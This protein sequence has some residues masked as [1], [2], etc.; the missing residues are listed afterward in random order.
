MIISSLNTRK[1]TYL[2][3]LS[4]KSNKKWISLFTARR[5]SIANEASTELDTKIPDYVDLSACWDKASENIEHI[6]CGLLKGMKIVPNF[7]SEAEEN[8]LFAEIEPYMKRM[9]YEF[10]HWD[11]AIHGFRE[12]ER[13]EWSGIG[14][15]AL[16]RARRHSLEDVTT[17][18]PHTHVLD[19]D[20]KGYIKP[21]VDAVRFCGRTVAGLCLLSPAV[22]RLRHSEQTDLFADFLLSR[23]CLYIMKDV[24]R[25]DFTHEILQNDL[26]HFKGYHVPRTRRISL[27][28]RSQPISQ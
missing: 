22:M 5:Q 17:A 13:T 24:A 14:A 19:L 7:I 27:I 9:R 20:E 8:A 10:D 16:Q 3:L 2:V 1:I 23:R 21:H 18:L 11:D 25:Y 6:K 12:T 26:S 4:I 15:E 28:N